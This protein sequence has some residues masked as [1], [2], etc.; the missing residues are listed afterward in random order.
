M[1]Y[2]RV[3]CKVLDVLLMAIKGSIA[4]RERDVWAD[5]SLACIKYILAV[6]KLA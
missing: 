3:T 1:Q 6:K 2:S 4:N 5:Y